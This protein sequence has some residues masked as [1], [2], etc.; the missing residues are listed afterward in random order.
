M[1]QIK[2]L[3]T[4]T[5]PPSQKKKIKIKKRKLKNSFKGISWAVPGG[6][7]PRNMNSKLTEGKKVLKTITGHKTNQITICL[8]V[9]ETTANYFHSVNFQLKICFHINGK[10]EKK[11]R[12][13]KG[14]SSFWKF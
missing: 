6:L 7:R 10:R 12:K 13:E 3:N 1:F 8:A 5:S 4:D 9:V 2:L 14:D 11:K